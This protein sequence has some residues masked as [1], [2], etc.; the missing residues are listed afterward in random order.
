MHFGKKPYI[1]VADVIYLIKKLFC[2]LVF[3]VDVFYQVHFDTFNKTFFNRCALRG[4][5]MSYGAFCFFYGFF[6]LLSA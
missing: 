1:N 5:P 6:S 4:Q 3:K 2:N